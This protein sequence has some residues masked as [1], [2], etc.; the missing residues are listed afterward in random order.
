MITLVPA[1]AE[2]VEAVRSHFVGHPVAV[3]T[4]G[5][6]GVVVIIE[7]VPVGSAYVP[8]VTWLGFQISAAYPDADVYPHYTGVLTRAD[9]QPHGPAMQQVQ[10]QDRPAM[11]ISRRSNRRDAAVDNAALKAERIRRWLADQ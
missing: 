4:D 10:W 7:D 9:G 3:R 1:I 8:S 2:A 6:G 5:A 11:Q